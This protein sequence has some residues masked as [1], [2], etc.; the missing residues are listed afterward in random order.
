M[1]FGYFHISP[2][3]HIVIKKKSWNL[4]KSWNTGI[5][6]CTAVFNISFSWLRHILQRSA[7]HLCMTWCNPEWILNKSAHTFKMIIPSLHS[8]LRLSHMI[9]YQLWQRTSIFRCMKNGTRFSIS[10]FKWINYFI[11]GVGPCHLSR[12]FS[13]RPIL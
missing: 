10:I 1:L 12:I 8:W 2:W 4:Q 7:D 9:H 13:T 11:H 5:S 3:G 6:H